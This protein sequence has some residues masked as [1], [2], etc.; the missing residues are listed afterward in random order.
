LGLRPSH[1]R[2]CTAPGQRRVSGRARPQGVPAAGD[3][4]EFVE[5]VCPNFLDDDGDQYTI[6]GGPDG[7][8]EI[9]A[10]VAGP[11][12]IRYV[13][14]SADIAEPSRWPPAFAEAFAFRLAWQISDELGADKA[15]KDRVLKASDRALL[16]ARRANARTKSHRRAH[17]GDWI[18]ARHSGVERAP[19]V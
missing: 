3:L 2:H 11:I 8:Q 19:G 7:G 10:D 18:R 15:R 12:T 14:D 6:E 1:R 4:V 9:L 5:I 13:R 17:A 16:K